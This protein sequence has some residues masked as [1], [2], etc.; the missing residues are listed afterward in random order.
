VGRLRGKT[1]AGRLAL[2]DALLVRLFSD[3]LAHGVV[4]V[5]TGERADTVLELASLL[6]ALGASLV[7]LEV[8]PNRA[9]VA[10]AALAGRGVPVLQADALEAVEGPGR[11]V[12]R[13]ANVLRQYPTEM[14]RM[15]HA[16]LASRA[17]VGGVVLEGSCDAG[18]DVGTFHVLRV[19]P[20]G[21][22][23]EGVVFFSSF[24]QGFAPIQMRDWLPR[25]L[26]KEVRSGGA[27]QDFF[28]AWRSAWSA[29]RVGTPAVD[30]REAAKVMGVR[31]VDLSDVR[32]EAAA[33]FWEPA[34]GV[35]TPTGWSAG[36]ER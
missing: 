30:F 21:V 18:G 36:A 2:W 11:G 6:D 12:V 32:P 5:G 15:A 34:G 13:C 19:T 23:R 9:A 16:G 7:A 24:A 31:W 35:P 3:L 25:D 17:Q 28:G 1:R 4:E 10:R 27:L 14:V 29:H 22:K 8:H 33:M 20:T 26:R